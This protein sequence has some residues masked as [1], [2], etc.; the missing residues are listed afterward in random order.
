MKMLE[1]YQHILN[2]CGY[3]VSE[4]GKVRKQLND[5]SVPVTVNINDESR[6]LVLPTKA[7]LNSPDVLDYL[8][9]HPFVENLARGESK[10][11]SFI[12][13]ELIRHYGVASMYLMGEIV[14]ISSG[15]VKH[16]D[17]TA[18]QKEF[19][20][21][22]GKIDVK[23]QESFSKI[24]MALANSNGK[25]TAFTLSLRKGFTVNGKSHSRVAI[26]SSPLADEVYKVVELCN[27]Q[28]DYTPKIFGVAV[29]KSDLPILI[30]VCE[31]FFPDSQD[32]QKHGFYGTSDATDAPYVESF[33]RSLVTLPKYTN[34]IAETFFSGRGAVYSKE[35]SLEE[36]K[37]TT[38]DVSWIKDNFTVNEF[39]KEYIMIPLQDGN[40]G[41]SPVE[42][43]K[44]IEVNNAAKKIHE[45]EEV[46]QQ[47]TG[48]SATVHNQYKPQPDSNTQRTEQAKSGYVNFLPSRNHQ[49]QQQHNGYNGGHN[50]GH[51][52]YQQPQYQPPVQTMVNDPL[53]GW[54]SGRHNSR[55]NTPHSNGTFAAHTGNPYYNQPQ[56]G[57]S[58]VYQPGVH[59]GGYTG[60]RFNNG[61]NYQGY[62]PNSRFNNSSSY[63]RK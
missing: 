60:Q 32:V 14:K 61:N 31:A 49:Q 19:I 50:G 24:I 55:F 51:N 52:G 34:E 22:M 15:S 37:C 10:V 1:A 8:I 23:F 41:I 58:L 21:K 56:G 16:T 36:L 5:K 54:V 9:F 48:N 33:I 45:W 63:F 27:K 47:A 53:K 25:N 11:I 59:N 40:E 17:L 35:V 28:K 30:K 3:T 42:L 57:Q 18:K 29:R 26:W 2:T 7:N 44:K 39:R 6:L 20:A 12:R 46:N 4:D 38:V 43:D 62:N 13:K